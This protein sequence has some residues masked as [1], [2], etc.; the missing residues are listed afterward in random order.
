MSYR[1]HFSRPYAT[2]GA[3]LSHSWEK[4]LNFSITSFDGDGHFKA[5]TE[6]Q[7]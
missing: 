6:S 3:L 7:G 5:G 2:Q 4:T 1:P